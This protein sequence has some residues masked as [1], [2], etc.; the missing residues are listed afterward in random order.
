M[1][2]AKNISIL[3]A[4]GGS[5]LMVMLV[6]VLFF[7]PTPSSLR[8]DITAPSLTSSVLSVTDKNVSDPVQ[9]TDESIDP[10]Q[11]YDYKESEETLKAIQEFV[12][13]ND[14]DTAKKLYDALHAAWYQKADQSMGWEVEGEAI[15]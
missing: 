10:N 6:S 5:I 11:F 9:V 12:E 13:K 1:G 15:R 4:L 7:V 8:A 14:P 2:Q 3:L